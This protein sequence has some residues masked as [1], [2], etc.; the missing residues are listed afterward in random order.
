MNLMGLLLKKYLS[1]SDNGGSIS[2]NVAPLNLQ[3]H[4]VTKSFYYRTP[5][6]DICSEQKCFGLAAYCVR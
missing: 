5:K 3:F 2:P 4:D 6:K 1:Y